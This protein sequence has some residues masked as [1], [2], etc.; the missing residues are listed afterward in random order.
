MLGLKLKVLLNSPN[1][2]TVNNYNQ[3]LTVVRRLSPL[4]LI[5]RFLFDCSFFLL[6]FTLH[7]LF[8]LFFAVALDVAL[9]LLLFKCCL[10]GYVGLCA[11]VC[12]IQCVAHNKMRKL[13]ANVH[14]LNCADSIALFCFICN[15]SR[16]YKWLFL[17]LMLYFFHHH[18]R[19][20]HRH[21]H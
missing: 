7:F 1:K 9:L 17:L 3:V 15:E 11:V 10:V 8:E 4:F 20:H 21:R 5:I 13:F 6:C 12:T 16:I 14:M 2:W 19:C 18:H